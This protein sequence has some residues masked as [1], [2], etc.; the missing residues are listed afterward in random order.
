MRKVLAF[1]RPPASRQQEGVFR[2]HRILRE[3]HI[4]HSIYYSVIREEWPQVRDQLEAEQSTYASAHT[5]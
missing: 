5:A 3:G 4:R 2:D 1:C